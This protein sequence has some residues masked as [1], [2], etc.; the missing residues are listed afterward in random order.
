M[1]IRDLL[2]LLQFLDRNVTVVKE[3]E[4]GEVKENVTSVDL[5]VRLVH[6][7]IRKLIRTDRVPQYAQVPQVVGPT[8]E[9]LQEFTQVPNL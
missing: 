4:V 2:R 5:I 8:R 7:V 6:K 1:G 9:L 3:S